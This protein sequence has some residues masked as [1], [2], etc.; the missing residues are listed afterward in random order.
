MRLC[1]A[2]AEAVKRGKQMPERHTEVVYE[3]DSSK[4]FVVH[5]RNQE[6]SLEKTNQDFWNTGRW[7]VHRVK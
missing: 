2:C 4:V 7:P 1:E 5:G 3:A 6:A